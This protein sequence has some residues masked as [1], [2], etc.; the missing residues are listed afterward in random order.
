MTEDEAKTKWCPLAQ[1]SFRSDEIQ[2]C[3]ASNCMMWRWTDERGKIQGSGDWVP[4]TG[5]CGLAGKL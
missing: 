2:V 4:I 5:F 3:A 1:I